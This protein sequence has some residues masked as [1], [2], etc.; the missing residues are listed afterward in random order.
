[1]SI[2]P[3]YFEF[4]III[5]DRNSYSSQVIS[6]IISNGDIIGSIIL[7][8][9]YEDKMINDSDIQIIKTITSFLSSQ[10]EI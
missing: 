5:D 10:V 8:S 3:S 6:P 1:S 7:V 9:F 2:K 4:E